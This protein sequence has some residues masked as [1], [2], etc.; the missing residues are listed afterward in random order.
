[1]S[2]LLLKGFFATLLD[3]SQVFNGLFFFFTIRRGSLFWILAT[4]QL[5]SGQESLSFDY[6]FYAASVI[7]KH[8]NCSS[9]LTYHFIHF[10]FFFFIWCSVTR[11]AALP[12]IRD[13]LWGPTFTHWSSDSCLDRK[14]RAYIQ[15]KKMVTFRQGV[16]AVQSDL[17]F[18]TELSQ[19]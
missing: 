16:H 9:S 19:W 11:R 6:R 14:I 13:S 5:K 7:I 2:W 8:T 1:M 15:T 17:I 12:G 4:P 10:F 18:H 3:L